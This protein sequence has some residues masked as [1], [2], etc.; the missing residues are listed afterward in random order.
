MG[1]ENER[2]MKQKLRALRAELV[3]SGPGAPGGAQPKAGEPPKS[4]EPK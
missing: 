4:T 1:P 2:A 3:Q